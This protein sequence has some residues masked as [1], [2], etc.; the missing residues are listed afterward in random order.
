MTPNDINL[1][2]KH[3][4]VTGGAS[5]LGLAIAH[6]LSRSGATVAI[7]DRDAAAAEKAEQDIQASTAIEA[8]VADF[9][10]VE[11]A[12]KK[13]VA[14]FGKIDILINNAGITGPNA[15]TWDYDI[16]TWRDVISVNL[17][18][19]FHVSKAVVPV[20][21]AADYGR[22]VNVASVAGKDGNPNASAYSASKA[23]VIAL[24]KSLAKEL[25]ET[26]IRVNC[27]TPAAVETPL[28]KQMSQEHIQFMLSKI[29]LGRFG[30]PE[31]IAAL[32]AW[33]SSDECS[34]STGAIFDLSGGRSTY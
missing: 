33:L 6:R 5:G 20:M 22:V 17:F 30:R 1:T 29:P 4:V 24:T 7:W 13:T 19:V 25:V 27:I 8:N 10:S 34:F 21:R 31:E 18:G 28:F 3:A 9:D 32:V 11:L 15:T 23:G 16:S 2:G 12:V 26:E 14:K